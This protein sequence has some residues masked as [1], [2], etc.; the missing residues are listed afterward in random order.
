[1]KI[2]KLMT[3][4]AIVAFTA[5]TA[6]AADLSATTKINALPKAGMVKLSGTVTEVDDANE[7]TLQ[8]DTGAIDIESKNRLYLAVGDKVTVNGE[9]DDG[10]FFTD[11]K[12]NSVTKEIMNDIETSAGTST[13]FESNTEI[14]E[15]GNTKVKN[16]VRYD[17][18]VD[19]DAEITPA[20]PMNED[21][22]SGTIEKFNNEHSKDVDLDID[23]DV[24]K[25]VDTDASAGVGVKAGM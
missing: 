18:D 15:N 10:I 24:D 6:F 8:D 11:I 23:V 4:A 3:T 16:P 17:A 7:F 9:V 20:E 2:S 5:S 14:N 19:V 13:E 22:K 21:A 1:M 25:K 12:A